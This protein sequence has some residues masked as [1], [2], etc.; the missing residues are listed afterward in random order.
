[1]EPR[2]LVVYQNDP[3]AA[4]AL[5]VSLSQHFESVRLASRYDEVRPAITG[6]HADVL[7]LDMEKCQPGEIAL[8]HHEFPSL[9][10]VGTHR[11]ADE[12][13]WAQ[14]LNQG[15]ADVCEPRNEVVVRSVLHECG[16]HAAA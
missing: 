8:L 2:K 13:L 11:L 16:Q 15:A 6:T 12:R 1:M 5:V 7:I 4:Q 3:R 14:A 9:C 10:I